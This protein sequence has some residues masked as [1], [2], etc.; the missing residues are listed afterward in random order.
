M[1]GQCY[2]YIRRKVY[3][4]KHD[5][6]ELMKVVQRNFRKFMSLR[7]WGW[8]IIIQKTKPLIGQIN[9]EEELRMLEEKAENTW[10]EYKKQVDTKVKLEE[11]NVAAKEEIKALMKQLESEQ[12]NLSQYTDKQALMTTQKAQMETQLS[13]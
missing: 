6:R 7:N 11:E 13:E 5:Q 12:G 4:V 9:L 10:G 1:Q 2:G 3:S 8:F